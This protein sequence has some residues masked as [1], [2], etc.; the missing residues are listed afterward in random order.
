MPVVAEQSKV[1]ATPRVVAAPRHVAIIMDG[2]G[3]WASER[4]LPRSEGH[5]RGVEAVRQTVRAAIE[6][7]IGYLTLFSFS[8]E[9][10]SRPRTEVDF[11]FSLFRFYI[12]RDVAELHSSGV[13]I[14][15][16]G[17]REG[18]PDDI[19]AMI[20]E[21]ETLTAGNSRL[22]LVFAFNYGSRDEIARAV[23]AI[24]ADVRS[25]FL[26]PA[27]IGIDTV[28]ERLDT[29]AFPDP[30]LVIRTSGELRLSNFL[31]WQSAYAELMFLPGYWPDFGPDALQKAVAEFSQRQRRYGGVK[32]GA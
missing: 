10:W 21:S 30:D 24:A 5:C 32:G 14:S 29:A 17:R 2:N 23:A 19:L 1:T 20:E 13:R 26:D 22:E 12:R 16:I 28:T 25:G 3:R 31:L 4:G 11:L 15:V 7:G 18:L 9:N 27:A 6:L 8:S